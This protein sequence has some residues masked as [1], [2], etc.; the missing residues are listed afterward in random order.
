M[1]RGLIPMQQ[2]TLYDSNRQPV[3]HVWPEG[4]TWVFS[5]LI[6]PEPVIAMAATN[7]STPLVVDHSGNTWTGSDLMAVLGNIP[8][9]HRRYHQIG[10]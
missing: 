8:W 7:P 4:N 9:T 5:W 2:T 1:G 6:C 3:A 10:G